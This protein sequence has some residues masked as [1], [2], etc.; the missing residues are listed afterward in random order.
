ML[1]YAKTGKIMA[2]PS[3]R[4]HPQKPNWKQELVGCSIVAFLTQIQLGGCRIEKLPFDTSPKPY[5]ADFPEGAKAWSWCTTTSNFQHG[6][7]RL[8]S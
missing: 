4:V 8:R 1:S 2:H 5:Q 7:H 6:N 3:W